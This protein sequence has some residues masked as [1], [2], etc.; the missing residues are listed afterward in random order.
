[1]FNITTQNRF[2]IPNGLAVLAAVMLLISSVAGFNSDSD[3]RINGLDVHPAV[4]IKST[5]ND[6]INDSAEHKRR[7]INLGSLLFRRG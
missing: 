3:T 6:S 2:H 4:E 7:G 5:E 1:M